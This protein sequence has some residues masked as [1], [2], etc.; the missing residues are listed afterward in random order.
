MGGLTTLLQ[1]RA[2]RPCLRGVEDIDD[3]ARQAQQ[4]IQVELVADGNQRVRPC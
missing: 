4:D 1:E 2:D 3:R